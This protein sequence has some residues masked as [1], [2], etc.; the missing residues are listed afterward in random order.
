VRR[1]L[2]DGQRAGQSQVLKYGPGGTGQL[3]PRPVTTVKRQVDGAE[4]LRE[5]LCLRPF[6][7]HGNSFTAS[8][9]IVNPDASPGG[10]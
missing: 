10:R 2:A 4:E 1:G 3:A 8:Q 7:T 6:L 9:F 5:P